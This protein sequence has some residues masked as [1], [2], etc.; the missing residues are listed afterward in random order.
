MTPRREMDEIV[1]RWVVEERWKWP[2]QSNRVTKPGFWPTWSLGG[3]SERSPPSPGQYKITSMLHGWHVY[4][5]GYKMQ[6][7]CMSHPSSPTAQVSTTG[8]LPPS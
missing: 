1:E 5:T 2:K 4:F 3:E 7:T 6:Y 8:S